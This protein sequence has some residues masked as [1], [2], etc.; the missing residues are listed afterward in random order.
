[1]DLEPGSY[2]V[3]FFR[4]VA[5]QGIFSN[6]QLSSRDTDDGYV[7][8]FGY[9]AYSAETGEPTLPLEL[10]K[11]DLIALRV[12]LDIQ[13]YAEKVDGVPTGVQKSFIKKSVLEVV[14][15]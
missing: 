3:G 9:R 5:K 8:S 7:S 4:G 1:M 15:L 11:N 10:E 6:L 2:E 14:L 13:P 12:K